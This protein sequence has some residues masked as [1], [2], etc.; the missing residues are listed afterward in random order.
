MSE[1]D[2]RKAKDRRGL[3]VGVFVW[4]FQPWV[5]SLLGQGWPGSRFFVWAGPGKFTAD[6]G[7]W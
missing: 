6:V 5:F 3:C 4:R 7:V 2:R 1:E